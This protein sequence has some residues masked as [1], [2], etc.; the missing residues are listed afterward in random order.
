MNSVRIVNSNAII[1]YADILSSDL[2]DLRNF[3]LLLLEKNNTRLCVA[4]TKYRE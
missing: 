4:L 1:T 2:S 3:H